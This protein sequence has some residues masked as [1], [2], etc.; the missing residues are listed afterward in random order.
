VRLSVL[1]PFRNAAPTVRAAVRSVLEQTE[2]D[3]ELLALDDGSTDSSGD[4]VRAEASGDARVRVLGDA[5]SLGLAA[6]LNQALDLAGGTLLARMDADDVCHPDRLRL[7]A[8]ALDA[9]PSLDLVGSS[10]VVLDGDEPRGI[11]R[12]PSSHETI[13][14]HRWRGIPI[15]HPTFMARAAW[16]RRHRYDETFTRAQDQELLLRTSASSR[17]GNVAAALLGYR[18]PTDATALAAAR[19]FRRTAVARQVGAVAALRLLVRDMAASVASSRQQRSMRGLDPLPPDE[20][21]AWR[22]LARTGRWRD[23]RSAS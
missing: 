15:A 5:R 23:P 11:R 4:L 16:L 21:S 6:R 7:Q 3:F 14:A 22:T 12:F 2:R 13:V 17:F 20:A 19:S 9:D 10:V 8:K 1:L 18:E